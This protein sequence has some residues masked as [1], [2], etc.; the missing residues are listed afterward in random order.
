MRNDELFQSIQ[1]AFFAN[2]PLAECMISLTHFLLNH[3]LNHAS[4]TEIYLAQTLEKMTLTAARQNIHDPSTLWLNQ[5]KLT[6]AR[7][8]LPSIIEPIALCQT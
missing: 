8:L 7:N 5:L 1:D 3:L 6:G 2:S 4:H